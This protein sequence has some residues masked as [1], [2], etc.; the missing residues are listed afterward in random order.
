MPKRAILETADFQGKQFE[1]EACYAYSVVQQQMIR[2]GVQH[3]RWIQSKARV[4]LEFIAS[5]RERAMSR[6]S[7]TAIGKELVCYRLSWRVA[8]TTSFLPQN[9]SFSFEGIAI[10]TMDRFNRRLQSIR[11]RYVVARSSTPGTLVN[12]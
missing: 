8:G 5:E 9:R 6:G 7:S 4:R 2:R 11:T 1:C 10:V 12:P 3:V